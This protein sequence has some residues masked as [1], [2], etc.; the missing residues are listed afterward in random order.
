MHV[1]VRGRAYARPCIIMCVCVCVCCSISLFAHLVADE[2]VE[3]AVA[4]ERDV[5][6]GAERKRHRAAG[7][8]VAHPTAPPSGEPVLSGSRMV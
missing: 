4:P 2:A 1:P 7:L 3:V 8:A 5:G 6:G